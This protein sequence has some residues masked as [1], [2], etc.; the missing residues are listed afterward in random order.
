MAGGAP[1][2]LWDLWVALPDPAPGAGTAPQYLRPRHPP[3]PPWGH[4]GSPLP[5]SAAGAEAAQ[6]SFGPRIPR[7]PH[8]PAKAVARET[9]SHFTS[10]PL[11]ACLFGLPG[12]DNRK[13]IASTP[14]EINAR[15]P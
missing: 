3:P 12:Y 4:W 13:W 8:E 5:D 9:A 11:A 2:T 6:Q 15:L 10:Q 7:P 14:R 1:S